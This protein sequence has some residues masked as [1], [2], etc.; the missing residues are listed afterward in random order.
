MK[1]DLPTQEQVNKPKSAFFE[2]SLTSERFKSEVDT[3]SAAINFIYRIYLSNSIS[4]M[5]SKKPMVFSLSFI[6]VVEYYA[7][8]VLFHS[9]CKYTIIN[10]Y[11]QILLFFFTIWSPP[12]VSLWSETNVQDNGTKDL[13]LRTIKLFHHHFYAFT[14]CLYH[15]TMGR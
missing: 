15:I 9:V 14:S 3:L 2:Y 6:Y 7:L 11:G 10:N 8:Y 1:P 13:S 5:Y 4:S 12:I